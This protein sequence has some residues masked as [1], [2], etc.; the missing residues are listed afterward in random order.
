MVCLVGGCAALIVPLQCNR[1]LRHRYPDHRP[2]SFVERLDGQP[3]G[4]RCSRGVRPHDALC[5]EALDDL[6]E[7][8][9]V[10]AAGVTI[11]AKTARARHPGSIMPSP[12]VTP[13]VDPFRSRDDPLRDP[14][15]S[16]RHDRRPA[17][18]TASNPGVSGLML[19]LKSDYGLGVVSLVSRYSRAPVRRALDCV[20]ACTLCTPIL[21]RPPRQLHV[22]ADGILLV[23]NDGVSSPTWEPQIA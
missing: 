11:S 22:P 10:G 14:T 5:L 8:G 4:E 2:D 9:T 12:E 1:R 15:L 18:Q 21:P 7:L 6:F 20:C 13:F 3:V 17:S 16:F 23:V 19:W